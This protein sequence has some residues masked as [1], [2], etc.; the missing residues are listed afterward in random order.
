MF[1]VDLLD[2]V[3]E[4]VRRRTEEDRALLDELR[5]EVRRLRGDVRVI[6]PR[7]TTAVSLVASDGGNNRLFFDP[8]MIQF[9]RVV[10]S[11]G[12]EF[13]VDAVSPTTDTEVL[14]RAQ[15]NP[16]GSP[17]TPLGLM[18]RDLGVTYLW[19]LSNMIPEAEMVRKGTVNPVWVLVYRDLCEWAVLYER[20]C[21]H[22]FA[23]D[24]LIVR[25][26]LLRSKIFSGE[27]FIEWRRKIEEAINRIERDDRRRVYL[28][29]IAKRS[30]V[31]TRY[32]L[33]LMVE[34]ILPPGDPCY[35]RIPREMEAKAYVWPEYARGA[36][37]EG[38]GGEAPKFV[39]GDMYFVR[40]GSRSGDP[41]WTVDILSSQSDRAGE[42]F[43]YLLADAI[44]GFPTP[45]YPRCLQAAHE[46]AQV[47][48]FD[49]EVL[50]DEIFAAVR[51]LLEED[52]RWVLDQFRFHPGGGIT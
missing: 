8:F 23:S 29:G 47:S 34:N 13:F 52:R 31:L 2:A 36:E 12:K 21:R 24:T 18:M 25:D 20:I 1:N 17:R 3:R 41:V 40:F 48:G 49:L 33:A 51:D 37:A 32:N 45:L 19:Q 11:Y 16:D 43:G 35:V 46:Y 22:T 44:N 50:Q 5:A 6:R 42:I 7:S 9:V 4:A 10:D 38:E 26:G 39:A 30:K 15:F 28:V 27:K 14:S